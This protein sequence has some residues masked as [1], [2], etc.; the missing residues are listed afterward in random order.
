MIKL[1]I[2]IGDTILVGRFKNK[3]IEVKEIGVDEHG[4]PTVNG[5]NIL[6]IRIEKLMKK[7]IKEDYTNRPGKHFKN[8]RNID[9]DVNTEDGNKIAKFIDK[10]RQYHFNVDRL[11]SIRRLKPNTIGISGKYDDDR[12]FEKEFTIQELEK[13]LDKKL[14][15]VKSDREIKE[16]MKTKNQI[17]ENNQLSFHK[18]NK[19]DKIQYIIPG[20]S[21]EL[22]TGIVIDKNST[23]TED[24]LVVKDDKTK[25]TINVFMKNVGNII[26]ESIDYEDEMNILDKLK[27]QFD[28]LGYFTKIQSDG[29]LAAYYN[30]YNPDKL[31]ISISYHPDHPAGKFYLYLLNKNEV[32]SK[33]LADPKAA[34]QTTSARI[35]KHQSKKIRKYY[36]DL[37][38]LIKDINKILSV[39]NF[40]LLQNDIKENKSKQF[41]LANIAKTIL[42][43]K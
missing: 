4:S 33:S 13:I 15:F 26:K 42:K 38:K 12:G 41:K 24:F 36:D 23:R 16:S 18:I 40:T 34:Y 30:K 14:K 6:K 29:S 35:V 1:D 3:R 9:Y 20:T 37:K 11:V 27:D 28:K 31:V 22:S 5:K 8:I 2:N 10:E 21:K 25:R 7:N 39:N 32:S 17:K 19:G 43:T